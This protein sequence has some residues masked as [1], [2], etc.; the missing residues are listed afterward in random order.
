M[1]K[2]QK[3]KIILGVTGSIA[4]Y[5]ACEL[6]RLLTK[7]SYDCQV[8]LTKA[9]KNFV[10]PLSLQTLSGNPVRWD[11]WNLNE[12]QKIDH[13]TLADTADAVVIA[14]ASAH[15]MAKLA[16]G[17]ADDLL[18]T[19]ALATKAPLFL[20]PA[21]NVN[22]WQ[23]PATKANLAKLLSYGYHILEPEAGELACGWQGQGRL[24][25]PEKIVTTLTDFFA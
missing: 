21:M 3:K 14:P 11:A 20:A 23:H 2:N 7:Q 25:E 8:V 17:L 16:Y 6:V 10:T 5:K 12:E 1:T 4:A 9:A 18:T 19:L 13:I 15:V 22:M 24:I